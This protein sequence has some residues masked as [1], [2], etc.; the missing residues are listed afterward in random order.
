MRD[1]GGY[2]TADGRRVRTGLVYRS[3]GL[4]RLAD[5]D[6]DAFRALGIKT[7]Y[8]LRTEHERGTA[9]DRELDG[10]RMVE[11]DV[12]ADSAGTA[13]THLLEIM[14]DPQ[15]AQEELGD[16]K[17][18]AIFQQAY[19]EFVSLPSANAA[20]RQLFEDLLVEDTV[21]FHCTVGKDR[22]G[23]AAAALLLMLGVSEDDVFA[24]YLLTNEQLVPWFTPMVERFVA[25]GGDP[26]LLRELL[27]AHR[28]YLQAALD[29]VERRY[30]GVDGYFDQALGIDAA[31]RTALREALLEPA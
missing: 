7:V 24:E 23:W 11:L 27:G 30:G 12:M 15:R 14:A 18:L 10:I 22:T 6:V 13:P 9:P 1:L 20:Y 2:R 19:L 21:L 4:N 5:E 16:G 25:K 29:E 28:V 31:R 26:T 17:G 8:D 3:V